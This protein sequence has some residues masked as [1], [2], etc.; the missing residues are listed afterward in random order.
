MDGGTHCETMETLTV[1]KYAVCHSGAIFC[2]YRFLTAALFLG[3]D[4][5]R[6]KP[7]G[8]RRRGWH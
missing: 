8:D 1:V 5:G 3:R 2:R 7:A 4:V 6:G